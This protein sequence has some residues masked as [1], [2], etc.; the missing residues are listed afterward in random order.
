MPISHVV[1]RRASDCRSKKSVA[2]KSN[3][4]ETNRQDP[5]AQ[6]QSD[7]FQKVDFQSN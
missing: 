1:L 7:E 2:M 6:R 4:Q 3:L 5:A